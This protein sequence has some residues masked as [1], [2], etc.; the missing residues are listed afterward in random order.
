MNYLNRSNAK[1]LTGLN[2]L[3]SV[4]LTT[5]H[6]KAYNYNELT[7]SLYLAPAKMSGYEVCP[8][9]ND[10]CTL[11]CLNES[12]MNRIDVKKNLINESRINKTKLF[13]E[14]REFFVN[15]LIDEINVTLRIFHP[16][17]FIQLLMVKRKTYWKYFPTF[18]FTIIQRCI[19]ELN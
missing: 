16:N 9:R 19:I 15:W 3:G 4:N 12:G 17:C 8:M 1:K 10:E 18:N 6:A 5:K 11:L 2:Y 13:F 7:Y 14:H